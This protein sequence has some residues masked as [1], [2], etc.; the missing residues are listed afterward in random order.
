MIITAS[1]V[2]EAVMSTGA[3]PV[4]LRMLR[5]LCPVAPNKSASGMMVAGAKVITI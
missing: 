1:V 2:T 3:T 4:N 5:P